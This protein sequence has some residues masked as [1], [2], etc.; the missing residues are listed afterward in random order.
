M[1]LSFAWLLYYILLYLKAVVALIVVVLFFDRLLPALLPSYYHR[2]GRERPLREMILSIMNL[3]LW[4]MASIL[5]LFTNSYFGVPTLLKLSHFEFS[6][7]VGLSAF[8]QGIPMA[9]P[10]TSWGWIYFIFWF[11]FMILVTDTMFYWT[12]R[13]LHHRRI[14]RLAHYLHHGFTS[15]TANCAYSFHFFEGF[16]LV[17]TTAILPYLILPLSPTFAFLFNV[18]AISWAAFL[19]CGID[20]SSWARHPILRYIYSPTHHG[21]HHARGELNYGLYFSFWDKVLAT[22]DLGP[23]SSPTGYVHK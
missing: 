21:L 20:T 7:W 1:D 23:T 15:P 5:I 14:Y 22:E 10:L 6:H 4:C 13:L 17:V 8:E 19:H 16:L 12:H 2:T 18:F 11:P 9:V 3:S